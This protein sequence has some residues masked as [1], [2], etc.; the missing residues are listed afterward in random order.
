[1]KNSTDNT[2]IIMHPYLT[3]QKKPF[4]LI[5]DVTIEGVNAFMCL[6]DIAECLCSCNDTLFK[7]LIPIFKEY[8]SIVGDANEEIK[9]I[10]SQRK[11][12]GK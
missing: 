11:G 7:K 8:Y 6:L 4:I 3:R 1:M 2:A 12:T 9:F 5:D 10:K